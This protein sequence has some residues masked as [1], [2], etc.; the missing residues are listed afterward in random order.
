MR[1]LNGPV[2]LHLSSMEIIHRN[3][4][5]VQNV[6]DHAK[7]ESGLLKPLAQLLKRLGLRRTV[8]VTMCTHG[9]NLKEDK[10]VHRKGGPI[11]PPYLS[12]G[13]RRAIQGTL[14]IIQTDLN[15]GG[16]GRRHCADEL[17]RKWQMG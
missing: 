9:I 13:T 12:T 5:G 17:R 11:K 14:Q 3:L 8:H 4:M 6:P 7:G 15:V 10:L 2:K 16:R 1:L